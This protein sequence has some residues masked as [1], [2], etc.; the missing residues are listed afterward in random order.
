ML[1][2]HPVE[3]LC[4]SCQP[5]HKLFL[6]KSGSG[7]G[8]LGA[9]GSNIKVKVAPASWQVLGLAGL[10]FWVKNSAT[11]EYG[12]CDLEAAMFAQ[13]WGTR[14]RIHQLGHRYVGNLLIKV[15]NL[16][17]LPLPCFLDTY[18]HTY[19]M[20]WNQLVP[21]FLD[22]FVSFRVSRNATKRPKIY[23]SFHLFILSTYSYFH[24]CLIFIPSL[25]PI[26]RSSVC[27]LCFVFFPRLLYFLSFDFLFTPFILL[28]YFRSFAGRALFV[29]DLESGVQQQIR[30]PA[31]PTGLE[32]IC[33]G[34]TKAG[35]F[36]A[37]PQQSF[38]FK[39]IGSWPEGGNHPNL[40]EVLQWNHAW[41]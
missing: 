41:S 38:S 40:S 32:N 9:S 35:H 16:P 25:P 8:V 21:M 13:W 1:H 6:G 10:V 17:Q 26:L 18:L 5:L 37:M 24:C 23:Q 11:G 14:F 2:C 28:L 27:C 39:Q 4:C 15:R 34:E 3:L 19:L 33:K 29:L 20:S 36:L 30:S 31:Q 7:W 12:L 22:V